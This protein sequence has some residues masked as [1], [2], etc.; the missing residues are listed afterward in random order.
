[1]RIEKRIEANSQLDWCE[2]VVTFLDLDSPRRTVFSFHN[3]S[4]CFPVPCIKFPVPRIREFGKKP[5]RFWDLTTAP[6]G[7]MVPKPRNFPVFSR[8][9]RET[10]ARSAE[11]GSLRTAP[12]SNPVRSMGPVTPGL[13]K[14]PVWH[15]FCRGC[16]SGLMLERKPDSKVYLYSL[17]RTVDCIVVPGN[18]F[19]ASTGLFK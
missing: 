1:M 15:H 4:F 16:A 9:N 5:R 18:R 3:K 14:T 12:T 10:A 7:E 19:V 8:P 13:L 17:D 6:P 11:T 2:R